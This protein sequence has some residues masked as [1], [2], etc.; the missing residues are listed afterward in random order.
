MLRLLSSVQD[1]ADYGIL[2]GDGN[3]AILVHIGSII[4]AVTQDH[5]DDGV[6][7]G[8]I[9]TAVAIHVS[10]KYAQ[11]FNC[12]DIGLTI[13]LARA[14][15]VGNPV[16]QIIGARIV[17]SIIQLILIELLDDIFKVGIGCN[18]PG[19]MGHGI[20]GIAVEQDLQWGHSAKFATG[21]DEHVV[22]WSVY[23]GA[24]IHCLNREV[25]VLD[26]LRNAPILKEAISTYLE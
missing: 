4:V 24:A 11:T 17:E 13:G 3:L 14:C 5:I 23:C 1:D 22:I 21:I 15:L 20:G 7:V 16:T 2:V 19:P 18:L 12:N 6:H 26:N 8:N 25:I 9:D 10:L